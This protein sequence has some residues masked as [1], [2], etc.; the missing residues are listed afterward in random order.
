MHFVRI[1]PSYRVHLLSLYSAI[2]SKFSLKHLRGYVKPWV[3]NLCVQ[4]D[5]RYTDF[6]SH[7]I[8]NTESSNFLKNQ[9]VS[10]WLL[11]S[12]FLLELFL[13]PWRW[14]RYVPP[15]RRLQLNRI[16]GVTSQKMIL[17]IT[18]A[19]KTSNPTFSFLSVTFRP[20]TIWRNSQFISLISLSLHHNTFFK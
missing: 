11:T 10:R 16:H 19:M 8:L 4:W 17:F 1:L 20:Y 14:R 5:S 3:S 2:V 9:Q 18:T 7:R 12:W 6:C 15:K 13:R